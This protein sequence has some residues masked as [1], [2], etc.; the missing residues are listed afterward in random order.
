MEVKFLNLDLNLLWKGF[1]V[2]LGEI[3]ENYKTLLFS[4][5]QEKKFILWEL[6]ALKHSMLDQVF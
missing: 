1:G 2:K 4:K 5:F 6:W 3:I